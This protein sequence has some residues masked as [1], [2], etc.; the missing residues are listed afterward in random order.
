MLIRL[1]EDIRLEQVMFTTNGQVIVNLGHIPVV[2][3]EVPEELVEALVEL[4]ELA[5]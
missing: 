4:V 1:L 5:V 2:E 3:L